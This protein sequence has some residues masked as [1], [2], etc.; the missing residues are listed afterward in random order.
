VNG[1]LL[2]E[3]QPGKI[4]FLM[5][6]CSSFV[7]GNATWRLVLP[8]DEGSQIM[9]SSAEMTDLEGFRE[10]RTK[11]RETLMRKM[12]SSAGLLAFSLLL[13]GS[14]IAG[15]SNKGTLNVAETVTVGGKQ[16][17]AGKY[18]VEWAGTGPNAELSISNGRET[19]AKVPVQILALNKAEPTS[20]YATSA[21]QA[22]NKTLTDI[23][24]GGKKYELSL[25]GASAATATPSDK[26]QGSN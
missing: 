10:A 1:R 25:G 18:Q 24:F 9:L 17:P 19:V 22:G 14:A 3:V 21:D 7:A 6:S 4:D 16:L 5:H 11:G 13:A 2:S 8:S 26:T 23:F 12:K 15:N 20:G